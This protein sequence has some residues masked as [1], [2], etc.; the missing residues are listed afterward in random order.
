MDGFLTVVLNKNLQP[1]TIRHSRLA[2]AA[3]KSFLYGSVTFLRLLYML[4]AM[5]NQL[6]AIAVVV[7]TLSIGQFAIEYIEYQ[8]PNF[9]RQVEEPLL[10]TRRRSGKPRARSKPDNIFIHPNQSNLARADAVAYELGITGDTELVRGN[11][12]DGKSWALGRGRDMARET[13]GD[14]HRRPGSDEDSDSIG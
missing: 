13:F 6:G 5:S 12:A 10:G 8:E 3:W 7:I 4:I 11:K 1:N 2:T 9:E 14:S